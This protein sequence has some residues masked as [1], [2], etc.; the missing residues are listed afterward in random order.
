MN[1][2]FFV[3]ISEIDEMRA[4]IKE[5]LSQDNLNLASGKSREEIF[6]LF[7]NDPVVIAYV[8][9]RFVWVFD[10]D[11]ADNRIYCGQSY[12]IN[13]AINHHPNID[14]TV[15][16]NVFSVLQ[17]PDEIIIILPKI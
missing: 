17:D 14:S 13:H 10:D 3:T 4:R 11:V 6:A 8:P 2:S 1:K 5:W 7:N 15:Y 12:F 16:E 9:A